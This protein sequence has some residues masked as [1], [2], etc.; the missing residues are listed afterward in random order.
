[1][2]VST[3]LKVCRQGQIRLIEEIHYIDVPLYVVDKSFPE[4][5]QRLDFAD[6]VNE[7]S[8][9]EASRSITPR[10]KKDEG[11]RE[12]ES[13]VFM[14]GEEV[15]HILHPT[16]QEESLRVLKSTHAHTH[17]HTHPAFPPPPLA[18]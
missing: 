1:M 10:G 14:R 17:T 16:M 9:Q 13:M 5:L 11:E 15:A 18:S 6:D 7:K 8:M 2:S 4:H 3:Q 12:R